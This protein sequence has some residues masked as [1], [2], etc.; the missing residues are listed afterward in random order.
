MFDILEKHIHTFYN[1]E[2]GETE[3]FERM[4]GERNR[5]R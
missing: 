4:K 5:L 1:D 3:E 2:D